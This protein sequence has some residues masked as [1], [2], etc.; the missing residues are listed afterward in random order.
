MRGLGFLQVMEGVLNM[1]GTGLI[2]IQGL[3]ISQCNFGFLVLRFFDGLGQ[4][5]PTFGKKARTEG[6]VG[7]VSSS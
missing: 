4:L 5:Q 3:G 2:K 6:R 1:Y 7:H